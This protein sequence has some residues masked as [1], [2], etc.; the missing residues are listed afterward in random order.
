MAWLTKKLIYF[1]NLRDQFS[2]YSRYPQHLLWSF[3]YHYEV[4]RSGVRYI[5]FIDTF[6]GYVLQYKF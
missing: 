5:S 4:M 2:V 1:T 6:Q 3:Y